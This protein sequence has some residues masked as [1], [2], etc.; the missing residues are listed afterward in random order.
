MDVISRRI[1]YLR[2]SCF[3]NAKGSGKLCQSCMREVHS[4]HVAVGEWVH[5]VKCAPGETLNFVTEYGLHIA[6]N[7]SP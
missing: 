3:T 1:H 4:D 2:Q 7:R 5:N 6:V